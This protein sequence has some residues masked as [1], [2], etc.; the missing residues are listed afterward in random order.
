MSYA[1]T[2]AMFYLVAGARQIQFLN[3]EMEVVHSGCSVHEASLKYRVVELENDVHDV[4]Q[5]YTLLASE[6]VV[7]EEVRS[8]LE[9]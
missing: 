6:K 7:V 3:D 5:R 1:A 8:I 4:E 9:M 2:H